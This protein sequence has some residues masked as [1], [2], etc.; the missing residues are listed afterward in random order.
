LRDDPV[1]AAIASGHGDAVPGLREV[2]EEIR[3]A[4][5][6]SKKTEEDHPAEEWLPSP[7]D[8]PA[9][10]L[11]GRMF[12]SAV[13]V[14]LLVGFVVVIERGET[15]LLRVVGS[16]GV[17]AGVVPG[18]FAVGLLWAGFH[19]V[20][21]KRVI[22]NTPTSRIRSMAMGMVEIHGKTVRKYA[23]V[24]PMNQSACVYYRLRKYRKDNQNRWVLK[25]D[26]DSRH[27]PFCIDDGTG[28][29]TVDPS[30]A[31]VKAK[32][33]RTGMPGEATLAF[34]GVST[35]DPDEKWI[36]DIIF[37]GVPLYVLGFARPLREK[38]KSLRER[39]VEKL[40]E[41]KL[42]RKALH[43]YDADGDGRISEDEWQVARSDA[44]QNALKDH[45]AEGSSGK[46]QEEHAVIARPS[47]RGLPF[48]LAE[49]VEEAHLIRNYGL[50]SIPLMI[51]GFIAAGLAL[52][53]F[54]GFIGV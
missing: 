20:K 9:R 39:T 34:H 21:L 49:A 10:Q 28:Q 43:R 35:D 24:S 26:I 38:R 30:G 36:E 1:A 15:S 40:R 37:E 13:G 2:V 48:V 27:V 41:L 47:Q 12:L 45:L 50:I 16:Y 25:S 33:S 52:Y 53:F 22:E 8:R 51:S 29:V 46:R 5:A 32:T 44:E 6:E 17:K 18:L 23:L 11:S 19:F 3:E 4:T 42:D 31:T 14:F 7:P 54:L